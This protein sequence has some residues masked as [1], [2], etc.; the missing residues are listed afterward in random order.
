MMNVDSAEKKGY[1]QTFSEERNLLGGP[2]PAGASPSTS[3][4]PP[5]CFAPDTDVTA[6]GS[7]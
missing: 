2:K 3:I 4:S 7:G 1:K 5:L 6:M